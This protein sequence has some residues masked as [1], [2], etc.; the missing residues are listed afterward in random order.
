MRTQRA[1]T[2]G[3]LAVRKRELALYKQ[4]LPSLELK[5]Q[6]LLAVRQSETTG[7]ERARDLLVALTNGAGTKF[8]MAARARVELGALVAID[9]LETAEI[10]IV[11]TVLPMLVEVHWTPVVYGRLAKPHWVDGVVEEVRHIARQRLEIGF[12][13]ERVRRLDRAIRL[14]VQKISLF[15]KVLIPA[16]ESEIRRIEIALADIE[17]SA[18]VR[19]KIFKTRHL[20]H[21][22]VLS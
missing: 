9:R 15:Q 1:A 17:R 6:H 8:S 4:V 20:R 14:V 22:A 3:T 10:Q 7:C 2:K 13:D 5:R 18:V 12:A 21:A 11:G 19:S 16:S